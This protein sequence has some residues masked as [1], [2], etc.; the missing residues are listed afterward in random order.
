MRTTLLLLLTLLSLTSTV[1][2]SDLELR[3]DAG[4]DNAPMRL[5]VTL[6]PTD[7]GSFEV[8]PG[9]DGL[10]AAGTWLQEKLGPGYR[11]LNTWRVVEL[12]ADDAFRGELTAAADA[13]QGVPL[14]AWARLVF[15]DEDAV[16]VDEYG[17]RSSVP[18][19][20][21]SVFRISINPTDSID[22]IYPGEVLL[23][24]PGSGGYLLYTVEPGDTLGGIAHEQETTVAQLVATNPKRF[25]A[26]HPHRTA[27][28]VPVA[29]KT[30]S[31]RPLIRV[32]EHKLD[33]WSD[34]QIR[35]VLRHEIG[36]VADIQKR[37]QGTVHPYGPDT[38]HK[39]WVGDDVFLHEIIT[40]NAALKEGWGNYQALVEGKETTITRMVDT[41]EHGPPRL[42]V[43][44][45]LGEYET[46]PAGDVNLN[47]M[48]SSEWVV[49]RILARIHAEARM[50]GYGLTWALGDSVDRDCRTLAEVIGAYVRRLPHL[51]ETV[52][53]VLQTE[54]HG[55]ASADQIEEILDGQFPAV[56][57]SVIPPD[58]VWRYRHG[59]KPAFH[60]SDPDTAAE[61]TEI[62]GVTSQPHQH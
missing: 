31:W 34:E 36:H 33:G 35:E 11:W 2:A 28:F 17:V 39:Y 38:K 37:C 43:E 3:P 29:G 53:A 62:Y 26:V 54:F 60:T 24:R 46:I 20:L 16:V 55:L 12:L 15:P 40:P 8:P 47:D 9:P 44:W 23:V 7:K 30:G 59:T 6:D 52:R 19:I 32:G 13:R 18:A 51:R 27:E 58:E 22:L 5:I 48:L 21:T 14:D 49:G 61:P 57:G 42:R 56:D 50:S 25:K 1:S 41:F 10:T 45:K 4:T